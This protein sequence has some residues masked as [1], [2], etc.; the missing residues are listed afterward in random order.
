LLVVDPEQRYT[1]EQILQDPWFLANF[2]PK[3]AMPNE[4]ADMMSEWIEK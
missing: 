2:S 1:M 3:E 4:L